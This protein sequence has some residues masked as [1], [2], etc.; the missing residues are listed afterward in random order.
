MFT[1]RRTLLQKLN[2]GSQVAWDD[3]DQTYR[4]LIILR[5]RDRGLRQDELDDLV[6]MVLINIFKSNSIFKYDGSKGRF[7]DYLKTITD[8]RAFDLIRKRKDALQSLSD[9]GDNSI[10]LSSD[11]HD[12]AEAH[13]DDEWQK[14]LLEQAIQYISA[15][16]QP[17]TIEIFRLLS[18]RLHRVNLYPSP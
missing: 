17:Q 13:W 11:D 2:M 5:G 4:K 8:R 14:H 16:V 1:T 3:F 15:E 9:M 18:Q 10:I 12:K 6:Q 7:R